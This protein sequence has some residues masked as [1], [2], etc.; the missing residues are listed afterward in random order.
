MYLEEKKRRQLKAAAI[1]INSFLKN[2]KLAITIQPLQ[3]EHIPRASQL[4]QK[5]NQF[6]LTTRRYTEED[7]TGM[8]A[9]GDSIWTLDVKD[10]FGEYGITGLAI[11]RDVGYWEIDTLLLSCRILGKKIEQEFF[12]AVLN[13]L[14]KEKPQKAAGVYIPTLKTGQVK[15]FYHQFGRPAGILLTRSCW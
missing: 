12:G 7:L 9:Q 10:K 8:L 5:T 11:V 2:L 13:L 15:D 14:K 4:T 6:N 1:D 3:L